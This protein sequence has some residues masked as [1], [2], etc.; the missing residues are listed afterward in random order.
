MKNPPYL[1]GDKLSFNWIKTGWMYLFMIP[2]VIYVW[3][4]A[5]VKLGILSF[6]LTFFI[7]GIGHSIG[8]HR[9]IIHKS[10]KTTKL[11][12]NV[13]SYLFVLT[14]LGSPLAWLKLHY[15]RDYWQNRD[16][17]PLYFQYHHSLLKDYWWYLHLS[18]IPQDLNR[19]EIPSEDL[20]DPWLNWLD[21]TWYLH[22]LATCALVW[23]FMGFDAV[24]ILMTLR[25]SLTMLGHWFIGYVTHKYGYTKYKISQADVS[26]TNT[27]FLGLISFGEGFHNNHHAHPTSAKFGLRWYEIDVSWY[28]IKLFRILG[29]VWDVKE[30]G[31]DDTLK[32]RANSHYLK[33]SLPWL[34]KGEDTHG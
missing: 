26:G 27:W 34:N 24:I 29:L 7:V 16:D 6:C 31:K 23:Y 13:M 14:G 25:I 8:L 33:W 11:F 17:S 28:L 30:A 3:D 1:E 2:S 22:V 9:G 32:K 4:A 20:N 18:Y 5:N 19:Y 10:Y 15:V 21:K 12:R